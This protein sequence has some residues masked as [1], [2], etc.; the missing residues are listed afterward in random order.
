MVCPYFD[1]IVDEE[2]YER[3]STIFCELGLPEVQRQITNK[4]T[5]ARVVFVWVQRALNLISPNCVLQKL[6]FQL[7]C[8]IQPSSIPLIH[9]FKRS[10]E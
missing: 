9:K 10:P 1:L 8:A 3:K 2:L 6:H 7:S 5:R 4:K